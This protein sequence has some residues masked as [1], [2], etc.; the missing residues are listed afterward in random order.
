VE[1]DLW[2]KSHS[3]YHGW[4]KGV[5]LAVLDRRGDRVHTVDIPKL[6]ADHGFISFSVETD[7]DDWN[8][9]V[10]QGVTLR[11]QS[12]QVTEEFGVLLDAKNDPTAVDLTST[13]LKRTGS[14]S[15]YA[16][17]GGNEPLW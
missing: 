6:Y 10:T 4:L 7:K 11:L 17:S 13:S 8:R 3:G 2:S 15:W 9:C 5:S 12:D 14:I 16:D 1:A